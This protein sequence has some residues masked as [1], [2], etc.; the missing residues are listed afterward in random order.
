M[1]E[2][3][4]A[5]LPTVDVIR[6]Q[7]VCKRWKSIVRSPTFAYTSSKQY[8]L[9]TPWL[10]MV[11]KSSPNQFMVYD[12]EVSKLRY[13]QQPHPPLLIS[14]SDS[15]TPVAACAG[16]MCFKYHTVN[17]FR[18]IVAN[19]LTGLSHVLPELDVDINQ[20]PIMGIA[21]HASNSLSHVD[22]DYKVYVTFGY[23]NPDLS[24]KVFSS[25]VKAWKDIRPLTHTAKARLNVLDPKINLSGVATLGSEGQIIVNYFERFVGRSLIRFDISKGTDLVKD[26]SLSS[27][28][29]DG[30]FRVE[31][32]FCSG[33]I[34]TIFDRPMTILEPLSIFELD[35]ENYKLKPDPIAVFNH[36]KFAFVS[37]CTSHGDYIMVCLHTVLLSEYSIEVLMY[38]LKADEWTHLPDGFKTNDLSLMHASSHAFLPDM[39]AKAYSSSALGFVARKTC[40][41]GDLSFNI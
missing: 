10:A 11:P 33:R 7:L 38:N 18:L 40:E 13:I 1:V 36:G 27:S 21:M 16:L 4:L 2:L 22:V 32:L 15:S 41:I 34:F 6:S 12:T 3:I 20:F 24:L 25:E 29:P 28:W 5:R 14:N 23:S 26:I 19:P 37:S 39:Q 9:R 30:T 31:M 8:F 35:T 17:L